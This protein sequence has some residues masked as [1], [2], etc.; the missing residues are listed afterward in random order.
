MKD[1]VAGFAVRKDYEGEKDFDT[2]YKSIELKKRLVPLGKADENGDIPYTE[3]IVEIVTETPIA[4][5]LA[6]QS[7]SVGLEAYLKPYRL[8]GTEPPD[9]EVLS[10]VQDFTMFDKAED[11]RVSGSVDKLFASLPE[12]LRNEYGSPEKLLRDISDKAIKDYFDRVIAER[13]KKTDKVEKEE[14]K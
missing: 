6:S 5:V 1:I 4:D 14:E 9:V 10:E 12:D 2:T 11:L 13:S 3:E 8:A 7:D